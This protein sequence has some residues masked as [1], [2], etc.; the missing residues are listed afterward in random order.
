MPK[1]QNLKLPRASLTWAPIRSMRENDLHVHQLQQGHRSRRACRP[2]RPGLHH[3]LHHH[4][5]MPPWSHWSPWPCTDGRPSPQHA[6]RWTG[7]SLHPSRSWTCPWCMAV[8]VQYANH[9]PR[10]NMNTRWAEAMNKVWT[11][12]GKKRNETCKLWT[13]YE[14]PVTN[15]VK[16]NNAQSMNNV[17]TKTMKETA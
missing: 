7:G 5:A 13:C 17:W 2:P 11:T 12:Y 4:Q 15:T 3:Q 10:M 8:A 14:Q 16:Q 6:P 9:E 1:W